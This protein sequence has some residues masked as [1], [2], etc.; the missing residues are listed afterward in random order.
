M[1]EY[2][3]NESDECIRY[4]CSLFYKLSLTGSSLMNPSMTKE[5]KDLLVIFEPELRATYH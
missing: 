2:G 5:L 3:E 1:G 4:E